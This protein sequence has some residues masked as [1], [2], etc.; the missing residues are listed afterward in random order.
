[1]E[2]FAESPQN[3]SEEGGEEREDG[4]KSLTQM[5]ISGLCADEFV[6]LCFGDRE[7]TVA[8]CASIDPMSGIYI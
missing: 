7:K 2:R 1:M 5:F 4:A 3:A 8:T 6:D